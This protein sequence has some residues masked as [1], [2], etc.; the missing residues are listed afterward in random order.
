MTNFLVLRIS[1]Y[2]RAFIFLKN[3]MQLKAR[4]HL[5]FFGIGTETDQ[6]FWHV[7]MALCFI[8]TELRFLG[9]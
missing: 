9:T 8:I 4:F 5:L 7:N 3:F 2:S 6:D 1:Y